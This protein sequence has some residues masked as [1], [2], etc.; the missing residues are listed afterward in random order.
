MRNRL[1][2]GAAAVAIGLA[3]VGD[4]AAAPPEL[5]M[6]AAETPV[7]IGLATNVFLDVCVVVDDK[8]PLPVVTD[9]GFSMDGTTLHRDVAEVRLAS[10][11]GSGKQERVRPFGVPVSGAAVFAFKDRQP[12]AAGTNVFRVTC[13]LR[14]DANLLHRVCLQCSGVKLA[15]GRL[16]RPRDG[17]QPI[18]KRLGLALRRAG[19]DGVAV[20]RIPGLV[21]TPRGTLIAVYD[22]RMRGWADLPADVRI[23]MSRSTDKGQTWAPMRTILDMGEHDKFKGNGAGD[24]CA[25]V[26][27]RSG[28]IWVAALWSHG[29]RGWRGSGPGLTPDETGQWLLVRSTD[30]GLTWSA[31]T[32]I[33]R[34]VK[35]PD[36]RLLLQGPGRGIAMQDG[37]LVVPAQFKDAANVPHA[38][39]MSSRDGGATWAI[40]TGAE[41]RTTEAQV[42]ELAGGALMLNMRDDRGGS[43]SVAVT[44]DLGRT[45]TAHP[46]SRR[47]LPEPVCMASLIR[48]WAHENIAG[49]NLLLFS[50]PAVDKAPRRRL[51]IK[52]S[53]DEG[54]SWPEAYHTLLDEGVSAG[55]SCLTAVDRESVGILYEGSAAHLVYQRFTLRDL[56]RL[57]P[58]E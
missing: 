41:P 38:T 57:P 39:L 21:A 10:V 3:A 56:L 9:V 28:T 55:Y 27:P 34:Q 29:D 22:Q 44:R 25:W 58:E 48:L 16:V 36:W 40:G 4:V 33:T 15:D 47:A 51:T 49:R 19:D 1:G 43:R 12:L 30:D 13:R 2:V 18:G 7:L 53:A 5:L 32:N 26:D 31:P 52:V 50:N 8:E 54:L 23:G 46:S 6:R 45:W 20:Y 11:S 24:P 35:R 14:D 42:V 37:T 17:W